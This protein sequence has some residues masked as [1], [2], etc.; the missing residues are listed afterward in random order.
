MALLPFVVLYIFKK[1]PLP[2][3]ALGSCLFAEM[4]LPSGDEATFDFPLIPPVGKGKIA[5]L[6]VFAM[7]FLFYRKELFKAKPFRSLELLAILALFGYIG[8]Y[9]YNPEVLVYGSMAGIYIDANYIVLPAVKPYDIISE[10]VREVITV[11][12]P[13]VIGRVAFQKREDM[14]TICNVFIAFGMAYIPIMLIEMRAS[15]IFHTIVYGYYPHDLSQAVRWGGYRAQGFLLHGLLLGR[16]QL[17]VF[18]CA[19]AMYVGG[20]KK[21]WRYD[22]VNFLRFMVVVVIFTKSAGVTLFMILLGPLTLFT[23][24]KTQA[25]T[26]IFISLMVF[27]YPYIRAFKLLDIDTVVKFVEGYSPERAESLAYRFRNERELSARA[28]EKLYFG[29]GGY[30]RAHIW[31]MEFGINRSVV[32]G[33]W[34]GRFGTQGIF[35]LI[36]PFSLMLFPVIRVARNYHKLRRKEDQKMLLAISCISLIYGMECIPN[37]IFS[38]IPFVMAGA[39]WQL[40][41]NMTDPK[42]LAAERKAKNERPPPRPRPRHRALA[43]A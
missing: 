34:V 3:A 30:M 13:F 19:I 20:E 8:T 28:R 38:N 15:P 12:L 31:D 11:I 25:R 43:P 18:M 22:P 36:G 17:V 42:Q 10:S 33:Y 27:S 5:T 40:V 7:L 16:I 39:C 9:I 24:V 4:Y 21:S 26:L 29:W 2:V 6:A 37:A 1:Y 41:G 35:G 14:R 32:D 23:S